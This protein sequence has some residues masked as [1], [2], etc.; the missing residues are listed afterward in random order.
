MC[1]HTYL[2]RKS[3]RKIFLRSLKSHMHV[4]MHAWTKDHG[5]TCMHA[6]IAVHLTQK[7][8][9]TFIHTCNM[10]THAHYPCS[11]T[12]FLCHQS[13]ECRHIFIHVSIM[14]MDG[15][16]TGRR[17]SRL[18]DRQPAQKQTDRQFGSHTDRELDRQTDI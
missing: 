6:C 8:S 9:W 15:R 5:G 14:R 13:H 7:L 18:T 2:Y 4:C 12:A 1:L 11:C 3:C 17:A 10:H 16:M